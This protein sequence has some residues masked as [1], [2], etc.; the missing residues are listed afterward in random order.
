MLMFSLLTLSPYQLLIVSEIIQGYFSLSSNNLR[1]CN[2]LHVIYLLV[3]SD[4]PPPSLFCAL[5][6]YVLYHIWASSSLPFSLTF[7]GVHT[8]ITP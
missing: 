3:S 6:L 5:V 2:P 7:P 4:S 8:N 1:I